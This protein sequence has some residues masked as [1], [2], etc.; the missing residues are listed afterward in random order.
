MK[1][2]KVQVLLSVLVGLAGLALCPAA[3]A[4]EPLAMAAELGHPMVLAGQEKTTY[5]RVAVT[6]LAM[7]DKATRAPIN[8]AIILDRSGSMKG[9]KLEHAK[10]AARM[11]VDRLHKD[12]IMSIIAY[13][14][15][16]EVV[17][18]ATKVADR[19]AIYTAIERLT[20]SGRTALFA[21]V[22]KGA[23]ELRKFL[24]E[25]RVNR[26]ILLSDGM[27][28]VGPRSR[29][30]MSELGGSLRSDGISVTTVGL[31]MDFNEDIL[32]DLAKSSDG[33]HYFAEKPKELE[34]AFQ[35]DIGDALS[36]VAKNVRIR[37]DFRPEI[38]PL[39]SLGREADIVDQT[40]RAS[41]N[42]VYDSQ[43]KYL[44]L[45]ITVPAGLNH[46]HRSVGDVMVEY[47]NMATGERVTQGRQVTLSYTGDARL[48][49]SSE[50]KE[51]MVAAVR[52]VGMAQ[53]R[54]AIQLRE[55]GRAEESFDVINKNTDWY[56]SNAAKYDD[57]RLRADG[58]FNGF[59]VLEW[60]GSNYGRARK[61]LKQQ[62]RIV[63]GQQ[64]SMKSRPV[65][66]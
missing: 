29:E 61:Q 1:N 5:L 66:K 14:A 40:A 7:Q 59:I 23:A 53:S 65:Q 22:S 32:Y 36:V 60:T 46:T 62:E 37:V 38:S 19:E 44:L 56:Y 6:G 55:E 4:A 31:G 26:A 39:R 48:A 50:N 47:T 63:S 27:A 16:V 3:Q 24:S 20:A 43:T 51:V 33:N 17:L 11:V 49:E 8:V 41:I 64:S 28:N 45:E 21:G 57:D 10:Q 54:L 15:T 34:D 35:A 13:D 25:D 30:E 9:R 58:K 52:E 42:Q 2:T 12:D 18:P